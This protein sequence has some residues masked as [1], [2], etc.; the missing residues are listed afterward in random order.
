MT[1]VRAREILGK[2]GEGLSDEQILSIIENF[3]VLIEIGFERLESVVP[4]TE[5]KEGL[6]C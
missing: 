5:G 2:Y 4:K 3:N 6:Q 1:V